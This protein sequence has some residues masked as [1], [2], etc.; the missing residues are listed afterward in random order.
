MTYASSEPTHEGE[1][2]PKGHMTSWI[3]RISV[4]SRSRETSIISERSSLVAD[5]KP[6][7]PPSLLS[8]QISSVIDRGS[9]REYAIT[10]QK[11]SPHADDSSRLVGK[12]THRYNDFRELHAQ[13]KYL[14]VPFT[15]P[16][17]WS[18]DTQSIQRE[19]IK[20]LTKYLNDVLMC[21]GTA[22]PAE[23]IEFLGIDEAQLVDLSAAYFPA[24]EE[25][26]VKTETQPET[27]PE[28][29][30]VAQAVTQ[31]ETQAETQ[32]DARVSAESMLVAAALVDDTIVHAIEGAEE[33]RAIVAAREA[34]V[35]DQGDHAQPQQNAVS[36][37]TAI[38]SSVLKVLGCMPGCIPNEV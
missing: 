34:A 6:R 29:E 37:F 30:A 31:A 12:A 14:D 22:L 18:A 7:G 8:A 35:A 32:A 17:R 15:A 38:F 20:A 33:Q 24:P 19:R 28:A 5:E 9:H 36:P 27:Q 3:R 16:R 13:L 23:L 25:D 26:M 11:G 21:V 10:V 2:A 1:L 4:S